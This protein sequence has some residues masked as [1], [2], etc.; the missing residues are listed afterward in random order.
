MKKVRSKDVSYSV[1]S[2]FDIEQHKA[3]FTDY[4]EV[5]IDTDGT[6]YYAVPC[7]QRRLESLAAEKQNCTEEEIQAQCPKNMYFDYISWL[8]SITNAVVVWID[9]IQYGSKVT[10]KQRGKLR[11][12]KLNGIYKGPLIPKVNKTGGKYE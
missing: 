8:I 5:L 1:Y 2:D 9:F 12:L 3:T 4:L 6:V 7:H 11:Q 10:S